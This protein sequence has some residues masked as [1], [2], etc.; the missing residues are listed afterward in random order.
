VS[1]VAQFPKPV[2]CSNCEYAFVGTVCPLCSTERAA[3][4]ALKN[5]TARASAGV[6]PITKP[7]P[8]CRYRQA[9]LCDC[10]LRGLCIEI[11]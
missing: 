6:Q 5:I 8:P 2:K 7:L 3:Y 1:N 9:S 10:G 11:A 4:T